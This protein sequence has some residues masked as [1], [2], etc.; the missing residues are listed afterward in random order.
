MRQGYLFFSKSDGTRFAGV[1]LDRVAY[2]EG[3]DAT[4]GTNIFLSAPFPGSANGAI[5]IDVPWERMLAEMDAL[6]KDNYAY[7]VQYDKAR[8]SAAM[9]EQRKVLTEVLGF[10]NQ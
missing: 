4:N 9:E 8:M 3:N 6:I 5:H 10:H 2:M 7:E 1:N